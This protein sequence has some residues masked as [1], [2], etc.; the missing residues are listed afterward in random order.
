MTHR[1]EERVGT[2]QVTG[3]YHRLPRT[4][5]N[6]YEV[7]AKVLGTGYNGAVYSASS[8]S[9]PGQKFAV[10]AFNF[11]GVPGKKRQQLESEV[12]VF[13]SMDHPNI[14]R[15]VDVYEHGERLDLVMECMSG[16]ELF[17]R[18][19]QV[20]RLTEFDAAHAI[21]QMLLAL[22]YIHN[23]QIVH[24]DIKLENFMYD[25]PVGTGG[26]GENHL[27]LIDFGFSKMCSEKEKAHTKTGGTLSYL[28]PEVLKGVFTTQCD[29][30]SLG[31]I[32]F[33]LLSGYMPFAGKEDEVMTK[34]LRGAYHMSEKR[35][36]SI[37]GEAISFVKSLLVIDPQQRLTAQS[38]L[39]HPFI[40][41]RHFLSKVEV[42]STIVQAFRDFGRMSCFRRAC[43]SMV[44]WSLSSED[45]T[46]VEQYFNA[47]D[48]THQ[49]AIHKDE[50]QRLMVGK[51]NLSGKEFERVFSALD[52]H[53]DH[54]VHFSDFL[55]AMV[56]SRIE[57][58]N[59]LITDTFR[60]F[61][62]DDT[63]YITKEDLR[64]V[65][66][67]S[68]GGARVERLLEEA[69]VLDNGRLSYHAFAA[70]MTCRP[71]HLHGDEAIADDFT[72]AVKHAKPSR[73]SGSLCTPNI[74]FA[75]QNV[76]S[77][78]ARSHLP[79]DASCAVQ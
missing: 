13:L 1:A 6:D 5:E 48:E 40:K 19:M 68:F 45:R 46:S 26:D 25:A 62:T 18:M 42:D 47:L 65:L 15:L 59:T 39:D 36:S 49:G 33:V 7:S 72:I 8:M 30:W 58:N 43:M 12:E 41:N 35:W 64:R 77:K 16:G 79:Q 53:H 56:C 70:Y 27:K 44:S 34:V 63:G 55:A 9:R 51:F 21:W 74:G 11:S 61:D 31:V 29:L 69:D 52:M 20:K 78:W 23:H 75:R 10:K 28:S 73:C 2:I 37:S 14:A 67:D 3:R 54:E 4:I 38:A 66:G 76:I 22:N 17:D 24:C 50:L 71:V 60:K 32:V 57:L